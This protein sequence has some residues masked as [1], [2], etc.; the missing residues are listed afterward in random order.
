MSDWNLEEVRERLLKLSTTVVSD[1]L[2]AF[3]ITN[4][5]VAGVKPV[6]D[7]PAI[8]GTAVTVRNIPAG[9]HTQK[10]HG[11]FV[12]THHCKPGDIIVVG[13]DGD[14]ENNG[15]GGV[16][17]WAAKMK[18]VVGTLVDGACRD[19]EEFEK[20]GYPVYA[21]GTVPRTARGRMIQDAVNIRIKFCNTQVCPGDVVFA[22]KNG[23]VV[24]PPDRVMEV[25]EKAEEI[26]EKEKAMIEMLKKGW[27][28]IE[29]GAKGGY[30]EMLKR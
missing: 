1:A 11:G 2:D 29:V 5:A 22:D 30:E 26:E 6:W 19:V 13:N 8:V 23:I 16:V 7:C 17:S 15:W 28:P 3:G 18:G 14:I 25:L 10:N 4:N 12:T 21:K 27:D 20:M 9:T 24:I